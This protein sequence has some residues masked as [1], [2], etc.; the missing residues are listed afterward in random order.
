MTAKF[1]K[2]GTSDARWVWELVAD[3]GR[4]VARSGADYGRRQHCRDNLKLLIEE[5]R[6][7]K[8]EL[9]EPRP[10]PEFI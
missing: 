6:Q 3:N 5:L 4:V 7:G 9:S 8:V 10:A 2:V 1:R